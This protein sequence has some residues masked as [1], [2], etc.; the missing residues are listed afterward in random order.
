LFRW[1]ASIFK[2]TKIGERFTLQFRAEAFNVLNHT[3]FGI[4]SPG[5]AFRSTAISSSLF[6]KIG[7]SFEPRQ[8]QL[9][10]KLIF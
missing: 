2:N 10:L 5:A 6:G 3:N 8:M 7:N 9:A 4:G 1:D